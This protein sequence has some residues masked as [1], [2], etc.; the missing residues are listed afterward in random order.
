MKYNNDD[1]SFHL[2]SARQRIFGEWQLQTTSGT[3]YF[4]FRKDNKAVIYRDNETYE[5]I[6]E[7]SYDKTRLYIVQQDLSGNYIINSEFYQITRLDKN[8]MWLAEP[9]QF[10][11]IYT[12][13]RNI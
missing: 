8:E 6:W 1:P 11:T 7:L 10:I 13:K 9:G 5:T 2:R 4:N 12:F 3:Y